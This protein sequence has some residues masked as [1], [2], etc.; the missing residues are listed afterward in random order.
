VD[1]VTFS[2][3]KLLGGPQAGIILGRADLVKS[4]RADPLFRALRPDKLQLLSLEATL[5]DHAASG[6]DPPDLPLYNQIREPL[7]QVEKRALKMQEYLG[8]RC[9]TLN[10]RVIPSK[11]QLGSGS[12]PGYDIDSYVL[13]VR[14]PGLTPDQ[15]SLSLRDHEVPVF[16]R[17]HEDEVL[18][19][20]RTLLRGDEEV[21]A[22]AFKSILEKP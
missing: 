4:L 15:L 8:S 13:S 2:G 22:Q 16:A 5:I 10:I 7:Q 14:V 21:I 18:L 6:E 9:K 17:I 12:V 3:D 1:L 20:M 19:D 11:A